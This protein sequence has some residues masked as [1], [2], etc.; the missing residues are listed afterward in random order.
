MNPATKK[1]IM[2][3][4]T[5]RFMMDIFGPCEKGDYRRFLDAMAEDISWWF[6]SYD[7]NVVQEAGDFTKAEWRDV[8]LGSMLS[9]RQRP[10]AITEIVKIRAYPDENLGIVEWA[11][12]CLWTNGEPHE[13]RMIWFMYFGDDEQCHK[14]RAY[15]NTSLIED[16]VVRNPMD[17]EE[18]KRLAR[19]HLRPVD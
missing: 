11:M 12:R 6:A 17:P 14:I 15:H 16:T 8:L 13:Q 7:R 2:V 10:P 1:K 9:G 19:Q 3:H 4:V 5:E 18:M